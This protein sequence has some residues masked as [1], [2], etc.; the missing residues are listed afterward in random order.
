MVA[1]KGVAAWLLGIS[2]LLSNAI[3]LFASMDALDKENEKRLRVGISD[4]RDIHDEVDAFTPSSYMG[5]DDYNPAG[6]SGAL[7]EGAIAALSVANIHRASDVNGEYLQIP[8]YGGLPHRALKAVI[9]FDENRRYQK[10]LSKP[11]DGRSGPWKGHS[12]A[13]AS[14]HVM[15]EL[16]HLGRVQICGHRLMDVTADENLRLRIDMVISLLKMSHPSADQPPFSEDIQ[17]EFL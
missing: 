15:D 13:V 2:R 1:G 16:P 3:M 14:Q 6:R 11:T 9:N 4:L 12:N 17:R 10:E 7:E 5:L 8:I